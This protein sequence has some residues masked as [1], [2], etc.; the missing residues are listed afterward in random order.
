MAK[1]KGPILS[2]DAS[3]QIGKSQVYGKWRGVAYARQ[4]VV[5]ANPRSTEQ[6]VTRDTFTN[7]NDMYKFMLSLSQAPWIAYSQGK[8]LTPRNALVKHNLPSLRGQADMTAWIGSPGARSGLPPNLLTLDNATAG[9]IGV[10]IG[11]PTPPTG[12]SVSDT[13][14]QLFEDR[15]PAVPPTDFIQEDDDNTP[16]GGDSGSVTFT[17]LTAS[18][19]YIVS[20][21]V[22]WTRPDAQLAYGLALTDSI[23][24]T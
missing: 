2:L 14:A 20:A 13:V 5:P 19:T 16:V 3:G 10:T 21:W 9:Q 22:V 17:G 4:H 7:L 23:A 24:A 15:D 11:V 12:W 6:L 1:V 8:P 18:T